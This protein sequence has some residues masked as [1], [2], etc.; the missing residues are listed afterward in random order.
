MSRIVLVS[1]SREFPDH[2]LVTATIKDVVR[3]GDRVLY[4]DPSGVETMAALTAYSL[5]ASVCCYPA[6]RSM[7]GNQAGYIRN[8]HMLDEAQ[9]HQTCLIYIFWDGHSKETKHL[10][11]LCLARQITFELFTP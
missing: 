4:G 9:Q 11:D 6:N 8:V 1:G 7:Y 3:P 5:G 10:I 2:D